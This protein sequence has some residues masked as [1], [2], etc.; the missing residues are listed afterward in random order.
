[1][2]DLHLRRLNMDSSWAWTWAG[3]RFIVDPWLVGSE[4]DGFR[5]LNEQW[6]TTEPVDPQDLER[7]GAYLISQSYNDHCH[8]Q[9]LEALPE[10][11]LLA[12][13]KAARLLRRWFPER[14]ITTLPDLVAAGWLDWNGFRLATLHPGR[15]RD[16]VYYGL[17]LARGEEAIAYFAHG[18]ALKP[19][20]L[21]ALQGL[22]IRLLITTCIDFRLPEL[23]GGHVN[24]GPENAHRL[25]EQLRPDYLLN[26][27][28]EQ[29]R[30]KG[31]VARMARVRYPG[32]GEL[33]TTLGPAFRTLE[34]YEEMV[35]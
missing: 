21:A 7:P 12:S 16:P 17:L 28:D 18:F 34:G 1:M 33:R 25:A 22:R 30:M 19:A 4:V 11:P 10:A 8:R 2:A 24:P 27:H 3:T 9:T 15:K 23:L 13:A 31:L 35:L 14:E 20:Q 26:T 6:H 32:A 5:W 29:K